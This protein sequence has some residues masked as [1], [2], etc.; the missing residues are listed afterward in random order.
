MGALQTL[1]HLNNKAHPIYYS[2]HM[3]VCIATEMSLRAERSNPMRLPRLRALP[4]SRKAGLRAGRR[5]A[6]MHEA[7]RLRQALRRAGTS[8]R[9][10]GAPHNDQL[11][12]F[13]A[14]YFIPPLIKAFELLPYRNFD[15]F[16]RI[17]D[18]FFK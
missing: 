14:N 5:H 15:I 10:S 11:W 18:K 1:P 7:F 12:L 4:S 3:I 2:E 8:S 13:E 9:Q 17:W 16:H 6:F